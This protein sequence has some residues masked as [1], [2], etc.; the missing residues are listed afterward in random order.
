VWRC[1]KYAT[2]DSCSDRRAPDFSSSTPPSSPTTISPG[3]CLVGDLQPGPGT[4]PPASATP[5]P[6]PDAV[7]LG[8]ASTTGQEEEHQCSAGGC[9]RLIINVSGQR[10]ETQRRT[11]DRFPA[12]LLGDAAKRLRYWDSRRSEYFLDRHRPSFQACSALSTG[13]FCATR[14]NQTHQLT[15]P[16]RPNLVHL[17][18]ELTV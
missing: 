10:F 6:P 14:S 18:N 11:L 7:T 5:E 2:D 1:S 15:D 16:T 12:T 9:Q 13:P 17:T 3:P 8:V 4:P